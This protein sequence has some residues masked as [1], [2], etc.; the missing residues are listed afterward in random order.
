MQKKSNQKTDTEC[1]GHGPLLN[2]KAAAAYLDISERTLW[3]LVH[4]GEIPVVR[5]CRN[6]AVRFSRRELDRWIDRKLAESPAT[7]D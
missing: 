2:Y 5:L 6:G 4:D 7:G 3:G 1:G